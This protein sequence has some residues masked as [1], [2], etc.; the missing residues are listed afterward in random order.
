MPRS[1]ALFWC[2]HDIPRWMI[3]REDSLPMFISKPHYRNECLLTLQHRLSPPFLSS[4]FLPPPPPTSS[5]SSET[6]A[7]LIFSQILFVDTFS[8]FSSCLVFYSWP[9]RPLLNHLHSLSVLVF[10][11]WYD[12]LFLDMDW[13]VMAGCSFDT[14]YDKNEDMDD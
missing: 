6:R 3:R 14:Q 5:F 9:L 7:L 2:Q 11:A 10:S 1:A 13:R 12:A 8:P 4:L